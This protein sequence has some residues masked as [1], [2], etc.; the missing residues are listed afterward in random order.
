V[1]EVYLQQGEKREERKKQHK[2]VVIIHGR[3]L[4]K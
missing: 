4:A 2:V 1:Y 3:M